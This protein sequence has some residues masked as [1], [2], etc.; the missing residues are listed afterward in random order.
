MT[1]NQGATRQ[2]GNFRDELAPVLDIRIKEWRHFSAKRRKYGSGVASVKFACRQRLEFL[3]GINGILGVNADIGRFDR[4]V[5]AHERR[6]CSLDV[7]VLVWAARG[8]KRPRPGAI[9]RPF[10][11]RDRAA[12]GV[13][14]HACDAPCRGTKIAAIGVRNRRN[15]VLGPEHK[16]PIYRR[17]AFR[18]TA[19]SVQ[20][21]SDLSRPSPA[22]GRKGGQP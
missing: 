15:V 12:F 13:S 20:P 19:F 9:A 1:C 6:S 22:G 5:V 4:R 18:P 21:C 8:R 16:R 10:G 11:P 7:S 3:I 17:E 2:F 14:A